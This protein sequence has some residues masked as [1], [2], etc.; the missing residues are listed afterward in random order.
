M[1]FRPSQIILRLNFRNEGQ[2]Q[3]GAAP[4]EHE[5][6]AAGRVEEVELEESRAFSTNV[7][8][9]FQVED[10]VVVLRIDR[11]GVVLGHIELEIESQVDKF[12]G[13]SVTSV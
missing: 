6:H 10:E 4:E 9:V 7:E 8:E 1:E 11:V 5:G 2:R 3:D 13:K 12:A